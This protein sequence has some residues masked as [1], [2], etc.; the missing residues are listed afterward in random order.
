M[1]GCHRLQGGAKHI[2]EDSQYQVGSGTR[3]LGDEP[4]I[5]FYISIYIYIC[6]G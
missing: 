5:D 4:V 2:L 1:V 6:I 3:W